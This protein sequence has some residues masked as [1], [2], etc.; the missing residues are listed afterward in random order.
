MF[1]LIYRKLYYLVYQLQQERGS[2]ISPAKSAFD[3]GL[4][5]NFHQDAPVVAPDMLHTIWCAVNR[6]TR[7]GVQI[8]PE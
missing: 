4:V 1:Y 3:R 6:I 8:G 2:R 5:V 7:K